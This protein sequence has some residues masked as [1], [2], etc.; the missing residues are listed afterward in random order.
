MGKTTP[1]PFVRGC[2]RNE[3]GPVAGATVR[4][5]WRRDAELRAR[6]D[7]AGRYAF[8]SKDVAALGEFRR[9]GNAAVSA[10]LG[11]R[12]SGRRTLPLGIAEV[13]VDLA[14]RPG[15][16][17][18]L[19][20]VD[21]D[22]RPAADVDLRVLGTVAGPAGE[23]DGDRGFDIAVT[24]D[25][26]GRATLPPHVPEAGLSVSYVAT[27]AGSWE[28]LRPE[29][30]DAEVLRLHLARLVSIRGTVVDSRGRPV[31]GASVQAWVHGRVARARGVRTDEAGC[32]RLEDLPGVDRIEIRPPAART[33]DGSS[34][35]VAF[36]RPV[37]VAPT[38][39]EVDLG[40]IEVPEIFEVRGRARDE[41]GAAV[42]DAEVGIDGRSVRTDDEGT[43]RLDAIPRG[44]HRLP[45]VRSEDF[46]PARL[47]ADRPIRV[48]EDRAVDLV[49]REPGPLATIR[50][51]PR[52][53]AGAPVELRP[54]TA[55]LTAPGRRRVRPRSFPGANVPP[56]VRDL[57][58]W[59]PG[60]EVAHVPGVT[61]EPGRTTTVPVTMT[62]RTEK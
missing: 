35:T 38:S 19:E 20:V 62:D 47:E 49:L 4:L 50:I 18:R 33:P 27:R 45:A 57:W 2:V 43:F 53:P 36:A 6:T 30:P 10:W 41:T 32:F 34:G 54:P 8:S 25:A 11:D 56:G 14:L 44:E 26:E 7:A 42:A 15:R 3:S 22:G 46:G 31:A 9:A 16:V 37:E 29:E 1:A 58:L 52:D 21:A 40:R 61:L 55:L 5:A 59:G 23:V 24:T 60:Y 48:P 17:L 28:T 13:E 12:A 51:L 39:E